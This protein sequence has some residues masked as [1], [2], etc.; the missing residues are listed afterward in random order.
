MTDGVSGRARKERGPLSVCQ[1]HSTDQRLAFS[2]CRDAVMKECLYSPRSVP[3][4]ETGRLPDSACS[5]WVVVRI[6]TCSVPGPPGGSHCK[7]SVSLN[8]LIIPN[9]DL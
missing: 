8:V 4:T 5:V 6:V 2:L 9:S 3:A 1:Q 7:R